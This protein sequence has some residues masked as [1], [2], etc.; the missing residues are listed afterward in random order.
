M[1]DK[2]IDAFGGTVSDWATANKS[3][4][5][6][7]SAEEPDSANNLK[8]TPEEPAQ[9]SSSEMQLVN[10]LTGSPMEAGMMDKLTTLGIV[11]LSE[12]ARGSYNLAADLASYAGNKYN[13]LVRNENDTEAEKIDLAESYK[14]PTNK[15]IV[16][17]MGVQQYNEAYNKN[18]GLYDLGGSIGSVATGAGIGMKM[19]TTGSKLYNSLRATGISDKTLSYVFANTA[20]I[21]QAGKELVA[22]GNVLATNGV[23][24]TRI[25]AMT[26]RLSK[27]GWQAMKEYFKSGVAG[28]AVAASLNYSNDVIYNPYRSTNQKIVED[29]GLPVL[30][31]ALPG[32]VTFGMLR[33][34]FNRAARVAAEAKKTAMTAKFGSEFESISAKNLSSLNQANLATI[35]SY[36][37]DVLKNLRDEAV[38]TAAKDSNSSVSLDDIRSSFNDEISTLENQ[39]LANVSSLIA[40][41]VSTNN[42]AKLTKFIADNMESKPNLV[43]GVDD[44]RFVPNSNEELD[45]LVYY[46]T[47]KKS[48][49]QNKI[50]K[51]RKPETKAKYEEALA[52]LETSNWIAL[53]PDGSVIPAADYH[54]SFRD[55]DNWANKIKVTTPKE[56]GVAS[57]LATANVEFAGNKYAVSSDVV[58]NLFVETNGKATKN[59]LPEIADSGWAV[60][61]NQ[62]TT[63]DATL[64]RLAEKNII[65]TID[66]SKA[67]FQQVAYLNALRDNKYFD[68]V[69]RLTNNDLSVSS[70]SLDDLFLT[71]ARES[72]RNYMAQVAKFEANGQRPRYPITTLFEETFNLKTLEGV[73]VSDAV[74]ELLS[75][76]TN[77]E[78]RKVVAMSNRLAYQPTS[79]PALLRQTKAIDD[80]QKI[81]E[82][83]F[84][85]NAVRNQ[86]V[87]SILTGEDNMDGKTYFVNEVANELYS[88]P[89]FEQAINVE[90]VST[91]LGR[92]GKA[93]KYLLQT[94]FRYAD[95]LPVRAMSMVSNEIDLKVSK[96]I[97][98]KLKPLSEALTPVVSDATKKVELNSFVHQMRSNWRVTKDLEEIEPGRFAI[99]LD[100]DSRVSNLKVAERQAKYFDQ[101]F[102]LDNLNY[103]PDP[104]NPTKPLTLSKEVAD[105]AYV[106]QDIS[107]DLWENQNIL[108][109]A[110]GKRNVSYRNFHVPPKDL[111]N[112]EIMVV[113]DRQS[114]EPITFVV[115][116]TLEQARNLAKREQSLTKIDTDIIPLDAVKDY[117][118][119]LDSDAEWVNMSDYS[120]MVRQLQSAGPKSTIRR[121]MGALVDV[122]NDAIRD[123]VD[124]FNSSYHKE[125][126][127]T[128]LAAM[129]GQID[130]AQGMLNQLPES[131]RVGSSLQEWLD[132]AFGLTSTIKMSNKSGIGAIYNAFDTAL[133]HGSKMVND[134]AYNL[135]ENQRLRF[136]E[137]L[138]DNKPRDLHQLFKGSKDF[139]E[140][141]R[142]FKQSDN[143]VADA[144]DFVNRANLG[145]KLSMPKEIMAKTSSIMSMAM[146]RIANLGFALTNMLS[147]P[148][149]I[150]GTMIALNRRAG[151][152]LDEWQTRI[153]LFG[154][155]YKLDEAGHDFVRGLDTIGLAVDTIS[156]AFTKQ[157][158]EINKLAT[159]AGYFDTTAS[160]MNEIFVTPTMSKTEKA[161][162][163]SINA[164]SFLSDK[165][166]SL[167][168]TIPFMMGYRLADKSGLVDDP[169]AKMAFAKQFMDDV[170]GN[171][172]SNVRPMIH[173]Q[174]LGIPVSLF[175]TY[176]QNYG[177]RLF[178]YI[179]NKDIRALAI[180]SLTQGLVFGAQ[181]VTV[182]PT[183]FDRLFPVESGDSVYQALQR[184]YGDDLARFFLYGTPSALTGLD[185]S[186][187]GS[188]AD[189]R[190][191]IISSPKDMVAYSGTVNTIQG[192][193]ETFK[194][195]KTELGL[196]TTRLEEIWQNYAVSPFVRSSLDLH[197]GYT[198]NRAGETIIDKNADGLFATANVLAMK[199]ITESEMAKQM[200]RNS[201][202]EL[203]Q[204]AAMA[205]VR[206]N[207]R[208]VQR[209]LFLKDGTIDGKILLDLVVDYTNA[210]GKSENFIKY[211]RDQLTV[212]VLP[213]NFNL[214]KSL[215]KKGTEASF[216]SALGLLALTKSEISDDE[217]DANVPIPTQQNTN[218]IDAFGGQAGSW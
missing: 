16:E 53:K 62:L 136:I 118:S 216:K 133:L 31:S 10:P 1:A 100:P 58:G 14:F 196:T 64:G 175:Y 135:S 130:Y 150:P 21:E 123:I 7:S 169:K 207:I 40:T 114:K 137:R 128:R 88:H 186:S 187:K 174:A 86:V 29:V 178:D 214:A 194:A 122:G 69:I 89:G 185:F 209:D 92:L 87:K 98:E 17:F 116:N 211:F 80:Y 189:A 82:N 215:A 57:K 23:D 91:T 85:E 159:E 112:K 49:L 52:K 30:A 60:L 20:K 121:S 147:L 97:N 32:A 164:L 113:V 24:I 165:S 146:L 39:R 54:I 139:K 47:V 81:Q 70:S 26:N 204:R 152:A 193:S 109:T 48:K 198:T 184:N 190:L 93:G 34:G 5:A 28:E 51:A 106:I 156:W 171:Y 18:P 213:K 131:E 180:Q 195:M 63:A 157:G 102:D 134:F 78:V 76:K 120:D 161:L 151:E 218:M 105:A 208:A 127:R 2:F 155:G 13:E 45:N 19:F 6:Y 79:R 200:Y 144:V 192:L 101:Q 12:F 191:P 65:K 166:E 99:P 145:S 56:F 73:D 27:T 181:G 44:I 201:Q 94:T 15:D 168:R 108:N 104:F 167:S 170:V 77:D 125:A 124:S 107:S 203:R 179:E 217:L 3:V 83:V 41:N 148:A 117:K 72:L 142:V 74:A 172:S 126:T 42:K 154:K 46:Q 22:Y 67:S 129:Q 188:M 141:K 210:G 37:I 68:K 160:L 25:G 50:A 59:I 205:T 173:K 110:M 115:G 71:K 90:G 206:K 132:N 183:I 176:T 202:R 11:T 149:T 182:A 162:D 38:A 96:R 43:Y 8:V 197:L 199:S 33:R 84:K 153:G 75:P 119:I 140:F 177:Q 35:N 111:T 143:P 55:T 138:E 163:R 212:S 36:E 61:Q 103:V 9:E 95:N 4:V 66:I 158:K